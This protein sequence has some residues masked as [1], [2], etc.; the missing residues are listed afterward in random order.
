MHEITLFVKL[1]YPTGTLLVHT[2]TTRCDIIHKG[3][4]NEG[5]HAVRYLNIS[6]VLKNSFQYEPMRTYA[7]IRGWLAEQEV[8]EYLLSD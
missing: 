4:Q 2:L 7:Y 8:P 1:N 5:L 6:L 3:N